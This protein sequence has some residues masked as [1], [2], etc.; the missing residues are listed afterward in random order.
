MNVHIQLLS[1][2]YSFFMGVVLFF[3]S[4]INYKIIVRKRLLIKIVCTILLIIDYNLIYLLGLYAINGG[5]VHIYF[6]LVLIFAFVLSVKIMQTILK[7][8][9]FL[10][11]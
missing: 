1:I 7:K 2:L 11:A 9:I 10:N 8:D 6:L 3:T 5:V 4:F